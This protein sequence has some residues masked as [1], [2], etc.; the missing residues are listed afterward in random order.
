MALISCPECGKEISDK[1]V[2]CPSCGCPINRNENT[3]KKTSK[4][5]ITPILVVLL[6]LLFG[7]GFLFILGN[8]NLLSFIGN[9]TTFSEDLKA[10]EKVDKSVVKIICYDYFGEEMSTGSGFVAF[11][12]NTIVTNFHVIEGA[13]S[14]VIQISE[15]KVVHVEYELC[16]SKENDLAILKTKV[17]LGL[18]PLKL[19]N[20]ESIPKGEEVVAI[21]SPLGLVNTVSTGVLSGRVKEECGEVLQFTAPISSGSSGGALFNSKGEV[22]GVTYASYIDGQ[23]LN[24]AIPIEDVIELYDNKGQEKYKDFAEESFPE[25]EL[26]AKYGE[27]YQVTLSELRSSPYT[28]HG[29]YVVFYAYVSSVG[30]YAGVSLTDDETYISGDSLFDYEYLNEVSWSRCPYLQGVG[31]PVADNYDCEC[32]TGDI[33]MVVGQFRYSEKTDTGSIWLEYYR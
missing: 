29:K 20:S 14:V 21:G 5:N 8:N 24:L 31:T 32:K 27:I 12:K 6:I 10:I 33:V 17:D 19:G 2:S 7:F 30:D 16:S 18:T 22:I 15:E 13:Y 26:F 3:P 23:N 1:A 4:K 28:Y 11:D 9:K 25:L